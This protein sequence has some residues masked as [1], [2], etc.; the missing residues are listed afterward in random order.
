MTRMCG[1]TPLDYVIGKSENK[2]M[3][4]EVGAYYAGWT[5]Y[6]STQFENVIAFQTPRT[7]KLNNVGTS[8]GE[9]SEEGL[10]WKKIMQERLPEEY[11]GKYSFDL[12]AQ[13]VQDLDN[14]MT[15][16]HHSPPT[17]YFPY[18]YDLMTYDI[19]RDP[20]E[21]LRHYK[22]WRKLA[23]P[24]AIM[25]MGIYDVKSYDN[26]QVT[27]EEFYDSIEETWEKCPVDNRYIVIYL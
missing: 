1:L 8:D 21:Q 3:C 18:T 5:K 24:R 14:V 11:R 16:L 27:T 12:L 4:I 23:N 17:I 7:N 25:L 20:T 15:V 2:K 22:W 6:L 19:S 9:F 26:F 13:E 10:K